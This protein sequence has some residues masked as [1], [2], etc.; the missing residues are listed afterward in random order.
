LLVLGAAMF[1]WFYLRATDARHTLSIGTLAGLSISTLLFL[2]THIFSI[3]LALGVG[4]YHLLIVSK[5][6]RWWMVSGAVVVGGLPLVMW[7][8]VLLRGFQHTSTFSIVTQNA[9]S[10]PE[11]LLDMMIV[12]SNGVIPFLLL[13]VGGALYIAWRDDKTVLRWLGLAGMTGMIILMIGGLTPII[14]PDRLRYTLVLIVPMAIAFGGTLANHR[15]PLVMAGVL[16]VA[17]L[18]TDVIMHR[19]YDMARYLGGRMNIYNMPRI[20]EQV[21]L[22]HD[23]TDEDTLLLSFSNHHDLTLAVRHGNTIQ[24]FY[25]ADIQRAH[26][27]IFIPQELLKANDEIEA[28]VRDA[29]DGWSRVAW[30]E[31]SEHMP[32]KRIRNAYLRA[33]QDFTACQPTQ[34]SADMML[35]YYVQSPASCGV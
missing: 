2:S 16:V 26:Y 21:P 9:L 14:P 1:L 17:W 24:D 12:Y 22:I 15:V 23:A 27:S 3:T 34:L 13:W 28:G 11:I 10:S 18:A 20:D 32:P 8:P 5:N 29:I 33:L 30:I 4:V 7:L 6:R 35:T 19:N 31:S 25:Y